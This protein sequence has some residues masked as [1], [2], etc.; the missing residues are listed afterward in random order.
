MP[1]CRYYHVYALRDA[2]RNRCPVCVAME[3]RAIKTFAQK[4]DVL[5]RYNL[6][7]AHPRLLNQDRFGVCGTTSII[8]MLLSQGKRAKVDQL[9]M[10]TFSDVLTPTRTVYFQTPLGY[11]IPISLRYLSR[12]FQRMID[13][14]VYTTSR[15]WVAKAPTAAPGAN[16]AYFVDYCLSRALGYLLWKQDSVRYYSEKFNFNIEFSHAGELRNWSRVGNLALRT[17][18]VAYIIKHIIGATSVNVYRF[19]DKTNYNRGRMASKAPQTTV[20]EVSSV[21]DMLAQCSDRLGANCWAITG[22]FAELL[23]CSANT[24]NHLIY[25]HWVVVQECTVTG[26]TV[27]LKIWSWGRYYVKTITKVQFKKYI[28]DM[29]FVKW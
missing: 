13:K 28:Q 29:V 7:K 15:T 10:A 24:N 17:N 20:T 22:I 8:Y 27:R 26:G 9:F 25:D 12:K 16:S 11:L 23:G 4:R 6:L 5:A 19:S 14:Y 21:N 2:I 3:A 18:T 1:R